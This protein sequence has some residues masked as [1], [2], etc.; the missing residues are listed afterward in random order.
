[1]TMISY[2]AFSLREGELISLWPEE[3]EQ[4]EMMVRLIPCEPPGPLIPRNVVGESCES[5]A[6]VAARKL[7]AGW[8]W[9]ILAPSTKDIIAGLIYDNNLDRSRWWYVTLTRPVTRKDEP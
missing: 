7:E 2:D 3:P 8:K 6:L 9:V 4:W 1:M 5:F